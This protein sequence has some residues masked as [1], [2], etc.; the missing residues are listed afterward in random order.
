MV[1][2]KVEIEDKIIV[3]SEMKDEDKHNGS[4]FGRAIQLRECKS[5]DKQESKKKSE[6]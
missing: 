1:M 6:Q 5:E 2:V 4:S 3:K